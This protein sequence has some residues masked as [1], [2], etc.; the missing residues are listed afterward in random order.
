[1]SFLHN[2]LNRH[3]PDLARS[4][5]QGA[6]FVTTCLVCGGP[7]VKPPSQGWRLAERD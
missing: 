6:A 1:M 7:M 4:H 2:L 3:S 5:W